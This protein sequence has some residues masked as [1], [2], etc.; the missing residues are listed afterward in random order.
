MEALLRSWSPSGNIDEATI[1]NGIR[2]LTNLLVSRAGINELCS[3][4]NRVPTI[5]FIAPGFGPARMHQI[6][7][8]KTTPT[9]T[10]VAFV[11]P[12]GRLLA[13]CTYSDDKF[14]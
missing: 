5:S 6:W 7:L 4:P 1:R 10:L 9:S 12:N 11:D 2:V 14:D 8:R 13:A 3:D